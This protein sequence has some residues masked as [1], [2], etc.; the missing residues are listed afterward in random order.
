MVRDFAKNADPKILSRMEVL[1]DMK[2]MLVEILYGSIWGH[3]LF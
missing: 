2:G 1:P 3:C